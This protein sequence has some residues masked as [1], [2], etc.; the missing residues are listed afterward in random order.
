MCVLSQER[1]NLL[2][3]DP[4]SQ[5]WSDFSRVMILATK[6]GKLVMKQGSRN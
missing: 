3:S 1:D 2:S 6:L 5:R 4:T